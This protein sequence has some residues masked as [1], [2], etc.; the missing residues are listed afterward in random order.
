MLLQLMCNKISIALCDAQSA[1]HQRSLEGLVRSRLGERAQQDLSELA[2]SSAHIPAAH[3][4]GLRACKHAGLIWHAFG[5]FR[6]IL[7]VL[8]SSSITLFMYLNPS[9]RHVH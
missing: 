8:L 1:K 3:A 6:R 4:Q 9:M 2:R 7:Q 5:H